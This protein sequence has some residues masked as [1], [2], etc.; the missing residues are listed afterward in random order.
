[1]AGRSAEINFIKPLPGLKKRGLH[2]RILI[3]VRVAG[4]TFQNNVIG[5]ASE[6]E[7]AE[8]VS[9]GVSA[10]Y[11]W[12]SGIVFIAGKHQN[13]GICWHI[14]WLYRGSQQFDL[15]IPLPLWICFT[16]NGNMGTYGIWTGIYQESGN[17]DIKDNIIGST[18][19]SG[20]IYVATTGNLGQVNG[21][22]AVE[23]PVIRRYPVTR[24]AEYWH[25]VHQ[26]PYHRP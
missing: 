13:A 3:I 2:Y 24:S 22:R 26:Q 10:G 1:M 7:R 11:R 25:R 12:F 6:T 14:L 23:A 15:P 17:A 16:D 4:T 18:T 21:I 8:Q 20:S 9:L 5:Y 19:G